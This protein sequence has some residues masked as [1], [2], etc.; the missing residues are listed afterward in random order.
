M[1]LS[2]NKILLAGAAT[3]SAGAY[4][5]VITVSTGANA[6]S[7]T[8]LGATV[9]AGVWTLLPS[10]N[11]VIQMN[12]SSNLSAPAFAN[13]AAVSIGVPLF[14]SDGVNVQAISSNSANIT[15]TLY[16]S[17]GGS[18]VSGTFNNK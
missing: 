18:A 11:V 2:T 10:T 4:F 5:Q 16:G 1:S 13:I 7:T 17:N 3:N 12:T 15:L 14:V 9:P 8:A 6:V